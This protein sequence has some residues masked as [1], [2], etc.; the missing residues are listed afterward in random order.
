MTNLIRCVCLHFLFYVFSVNIWER[1]IFHVIFQLKTFFECPF[2][3]QQK[4]SKDENNLNY[5]PFR[6]LT[7]SNY[8]ARNY[9]HLY[10]LEEGMFFYLAAPYLR[11]LRGF[12]HDISSLAVTHRLAIR[13]RP[14][15]NA[16]LT[17]LPNKFAHSF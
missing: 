7:I 6:N 9:C 11:Y 2:H 13:A 12:D 15:I 10:E 3:F 5:M 17:F 16:D 1:H 8:F 14:L 4:Y